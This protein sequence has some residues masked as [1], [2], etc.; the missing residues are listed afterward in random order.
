[1]GQISEYPAEMEESK[2][3]VRCLD[4]QKYKIDLSEF[5]L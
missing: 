2:M 4:P 1:L 5:I 3:L